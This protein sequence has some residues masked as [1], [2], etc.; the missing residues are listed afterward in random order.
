MDTLILIIIYLSWTLRGL[1]THSRFSAIF[2]RRGLGVQGEGGGG[3]ATFLT[4]W[5]LSYTSLPF[6]KR[7]YSKRKEFIPLGSKF[8]PFRIDPFSEGGKINFDRVAS[9]ESVS[10]P[11]KDTV[12]EYWWNEKQSRPWSMEPM[13]G[14]LCLLRH[15]CPNILW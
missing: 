6:W 15:I 2:Y 1:D 10:V 12:A 4:S 14:L 7:V 13:E 11:L 9:H 8:F 5:L 3:K